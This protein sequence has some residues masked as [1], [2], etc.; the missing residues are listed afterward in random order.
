MNSYTEILKLYKIDADIRILIDAATRDNADYSVENQSEAIDQML[1]Y[2][3]EER[4]RTLSGLIGQYK[5]FMYSADAV[6]TEAEALKKRAQRYEDRAEFL[7]DMLTRILDG[8]DWELGA[9]EIAWRMS[10]TVEIDDD[11]DASKLDE[12]YVKITKT[13][14]RSAIGPDLEAGIEVPGCRI[15]RKNNIQIK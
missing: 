1:K 13:P 3:Y 8:Q 4:D 7:K 2:A 5:N 11:I 9:H 6:R 10:K 14:M 15:V 12:K